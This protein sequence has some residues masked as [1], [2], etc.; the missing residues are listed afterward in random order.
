MGQDQNG[1]PIFEPME[2]EFDAWS[3][4]YKLVNV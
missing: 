4:N 1:K 2:G 3:E